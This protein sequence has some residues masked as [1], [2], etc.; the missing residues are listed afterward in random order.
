MSM[1]TDRIRFTLSDSDTCRH[2]AT[3]AAAFALGINLGT[4]ES[5]FDS[6]TRIECRPSQFA[7]FIVKRF[8]LGKSKAGFSNR[9]QELEPELIGPTEQFFDVSRNPR[10]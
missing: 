7:R 10:R 6:R 5:L 3:Q 8:E 2:I 1:S 4:A 9:I